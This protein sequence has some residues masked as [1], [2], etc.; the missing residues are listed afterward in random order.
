MKIKSVHIL[1]YFVIVSFTIINVNAYKM[2]P[3]D[4]VTHQY[5]TNQSR[6]IWSLIPYEII[7][8]L[9]NSVT[10]ELDYRGKAN[11]D[12]EDDIITGS[13]EEDLA[14]DT[15][16]ALFGNHFWQPDDPDT[17]MLGNDDYNDGL[18]E[19]DSSYRTA[20][21]YWYKPCSFWENDCDDVI[22]N[23][24]KGN[25]DESY[26]WLGRIAH[27]L[28]D[29]AQPSH[30]LLDPHLPGDDSE[31]EIWSGDNFHSYQGVNYAGKQ[32]N[33]E[34]L[35]D[36]F[37]WSSV[38]PTRAPDR[39][40]IELF[41]LF[42]YT[43]QK[44]QYW[45]SDDVDANYVYTD[46]NDVEQ[47]WSCSGND[48]LNLWADEGY[49]SC[50]DFISTGLNDSNVEQEANATIPHAMKAVAGL[51]RL[52]WDAVHIDWPTYRHD[53]L[54]TGTTAFKGDLS[55]DTD[56]EEF[57]FPINEDTDS[58]NNLAFADL[59][60]DGDQELIIGTNKDFLIE[61]NEEYRGRVFTFEFNKNDR[62]TLG[63][64][65][66]NEK[67]AS[68]F[69]PV[70][71]TPVIS[72]INNDGFKEIIFG[73]KSGKIWVLN[74]DGEP[75]PLTEDEDYVLP[76]GDNNSAMFTSWAIEDIDLDGTKELLFV[77]K[78]DSTTPLYVFDAKIYVYNLTED[79]LLEEWQ[80]DL[81]STYG[82]GSSSDPAIADI[83]SDGD[84][85]IIVGTLYDGD[86]KIIFAEVM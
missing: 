43:A 58:S 67:S 22:N 59:N 69:K 31:L 55:E 77:E 39:Q 4:E 71:A 7:F 8:H 30:V 34:D 75:L 80:A 23:Y 27:L 70:V 41:R 2:T 49:T 38:E 82:S 85:D 15:L 14:S 29:A 10:K 57:T 28:E 74:P 86:K 47:S 45:A 9:N 84:M 33:Y 68:W 76:R 63:W 5:I 60:K 66:S 65:T 83:D 44:T 42:W 51:Y 53:N 35:I 64:S 40:Y 21:D 16:S 73:D 79:E 37:D 12:Y 78:T 52:F 24:L 13:A 61:N 18:A 50:S 46:L 62:Y 81:G 17:L 32:Y 1:L 11:F 3:P 20:L 56:A 6:R 72:D 48:N 25:I 26:Y 36:N 54:R 19:R